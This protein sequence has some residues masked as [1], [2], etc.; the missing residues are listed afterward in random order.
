M[1]NHPEEPTHSSGWADASP[2]L[3]LPRREPS[4]VDYGEVIVRLEATIVPVRYDLSM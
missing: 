2:A 4:C 1:N 3:P